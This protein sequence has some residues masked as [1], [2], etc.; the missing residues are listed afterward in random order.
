MS[1]RI[2]LVM[3]ALVCLSS[4]ASFDTPRNK[5][6]VDIGRSPAR[7]DTRARVNCYFFS[8]F[9]VKEV[10]LGE[11]G[12]DRLSIV[13][14]SRGVLPRCTRTRSKMEKVINP[15]EWGGYF[16]G[17]KGDLVFFDADDGLNG[18]MP[19]AVYNSRTGKKIFED[20]VLGDFTFG[21][22]SSGAIVL[23]YT[24][25][26]E[27]KC[28]V[29]RDADTCWPQIQ[30]SIGLENVSMPDCKQGYEKSDQDMAKGRCQAQNADNPDCAAKK[31][32]LA[33]DQANSAVS[34]IAYPVEVVLDYHPAVKPLSGILQ[35]WPA[36]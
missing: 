36:D 10:D 7:T 35:C 12:A 32:P 33:R 22:A 6:T 26:L 5:K 25:V 28:V 20:N 24:R 4:G 19:F 29:P 14:I 23:R 11:K 18:G 2:L 13:P 31:L 30:K 8:R 34:V 17:V 15:S 3:V 27:T 9:M 1:L 16:K 21:E